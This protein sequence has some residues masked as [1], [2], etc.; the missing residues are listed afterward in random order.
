MAAGLFVR[1]HG[2]PERERIEIGVGVVDQALGGRGQN[3]GCETLADQGALGIAAVGIETETDHR[4]AVT[5]AIGD[6]G[7]DAGG[8]LAEIDECVA[9]LRADRHRAL[10]NVD[11][12]HGLRDLRERQ[13][14][15]RH[16]GR[17]HSRQKPA[18]SLS[19]L[20]FVGQASLVDDAMLP[21]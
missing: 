2:I 14:L 11:N 15:N 13:T 4:L 12:A 18:M 10:A 8:H 20:K 19:L 5:D 6:D 3:T 7:D 16:G 9:D 21:S 1:H 17:R